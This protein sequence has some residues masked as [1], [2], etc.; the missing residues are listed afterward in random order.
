MNERLKQRFRL[1]FCFWLAGVLAV[2]F[3]TL[4][5]ADG[6]G[7]SPLVLLFQSPPQAPA[8]PLMA[9]SAAPL[10]P[11][12]ADP[13]PA[14]A[15]PKP[16]IPNMAYG[17]REGKGSLL[18]PAVETLP[19]GSVAVTFRLEGQ[20]GEYTAFSQSSTRSRSVDLHGN[21]KAAPARIY[22]KNACARLVQIAGHPGFVRISVSMP[23]QVRSVTEH[24]TL[25]PGAVR[26]VFTEKK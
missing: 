23:D 26:I 15:P 10:P 6:E 14:P 19:D 4:R 25:P 20:P 7:V 13:V 3:L 1:V 16:A 9:E 24:V 17:K 21:W 2:A 11:E 22:P 12:P 18:A 5:G 8:P